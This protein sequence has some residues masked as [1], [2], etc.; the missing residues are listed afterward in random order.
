MKSQIEKGMGVGKSISRPIRPP[1]LTGAVD[2]NAASARYYKVIRELHDYL[3]AVVG[4]GEA[5]LFKS[6]NK[7][8]D[9][10]WAHGE[11]IEAIDE[12]QAHYPA[13]DLGQDGSSVICEMLGEIEFLWRKFGTR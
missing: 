11:C 12:L 4:T 8:I 9:I 10:D 3:D 13:F 6:V 7:T 2:V 5:R 1:P